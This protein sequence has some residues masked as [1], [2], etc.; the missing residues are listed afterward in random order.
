MDKKLKRQLQL[1]GIKP[2]NESKK[3]T[4]SDIE[5]VK[6]ASNGDSYAII[7]ENRKWYI[8]V[9]DKDGQLTESDFDYIGGVANKPK[10]SYTSFS[11]ATKGLNF[12]FEQ[13]NRSNNSAGVNILESDEELL[14]EKKYVLKTK[15][16]KAPA[17]VPE[18]ELDFGSDEEGGGFDFGDE[19]S[20]DDEGGGDAGFNGEENEFDAEIESST[21]DEDLDFDDDENLDF[22]DDEDDPIKDIQRTTG[23]LGQQLRDTEDISSDMTKW[24][25]KSVMSALDMD[26]LDNSDKKDLIKTIKKK[27][28]KDKESDD[29]NKEELDFDFG[30]MEENY[31]SYMEE[32]ES[33]PENVG[34]LDLDMPLS[35]VDM[36][37]QDKAYLNVDPSVLTSEDLY[38]PNDGY[39]SYMEEDDET[40]EDGMC[41]SCSGSGCSHCAGLG[42]HDVDDLEMRDIDMG[43]QDKAYL[44]VDPETIGGEYGNYMEDD[45]YVE[46]N[47]HIGG[48]EDD[49]NLLFDDYASE[50]EEFDSIE[51]ELGL[52][53]ATPAVDET[54]Y[55]HTSMMGESDNL[56]ET[57]ID[58]LSEFDEYSDEQLN[59]DIMDIEMND[60]APAKPKTRPGTKEPDTDR[61]ARPSKRPFTTPPHIRPGEEPRPKAK[62]RTSYMDDD[63]DVTFE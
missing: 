22:D 28:T 20:L 39:D 35:D 61:P 49:E 7:R 10:H 62:G 59:D 46:D 55:E 58:S 13:I 42:Y 30:G 14:D 57:P 37:I 53:P 29:G 47:P 15:K 3:N 24:V 12:M 21:D 33:Y 23:E 44:N 32:D 38:G 52:P 4:L 11:E 26:N 8:K 2:I 9:T 31:D 63:L 1:A 27:P 34:G 18:P 17:P 36:P 54:D 5:L 16:P 41:Q 6:K 50:E 48:D 40:I 45:S 51:A 56:E 60:P 25:A 43:I 19:F